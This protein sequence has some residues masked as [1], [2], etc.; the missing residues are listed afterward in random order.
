MAIPVPP[1]TINAPLVVEVLCVVLVIVV[2]P[3]TDKV[4]PI[5]AELLI[6]NPFTEALELMFNVP[7]VNEVFALPI[8]LA[9]NEVPLNV[10]DKVS[11][12]NVPTLVMLGCAAS[13]TVFA[14]DALVTD[15]V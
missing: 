6:V 13:T 12:D 10:P 11:P 15:I 1:E 7:P 4:V 2:I 9:F 14:V 5:V 8:T 3:A